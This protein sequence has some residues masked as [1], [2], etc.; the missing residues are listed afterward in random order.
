[1]HVLLIFQWLS[2]LLL[3]IY[4]YII[5][6]GRRSVQAFCTRTLDTLHIFFLGQVFKWSRLPVIIQCIPSRYAYILCELFSWCVVSTSLLLKD[7]SKMHSLYKR[8]NTCCHNAF[9]CQFVVFDN[10]FTKRLEIKIKK[11]TIYWQTVHVL[12]T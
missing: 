8:H 3:N 5:A 12:Y 6:P 2:I 1:M 11:K 4:I 7:C 10:L 9:N